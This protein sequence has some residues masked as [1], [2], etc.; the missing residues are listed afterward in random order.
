MPGSASSLKVFDTAKMINE[1][2]VSFGVA[3]KRGYKTD[4]IY[5][6]EFSL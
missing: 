5:F 2:T 6:S 4:M 1:L 3:V